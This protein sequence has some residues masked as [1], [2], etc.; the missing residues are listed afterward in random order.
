M[1]LESHGPQWLCHHYADPLSS[2]KK[3]RKGNSGQNP[4]FCDYPLGGFS[5]VS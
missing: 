1:I 2:L 5:S 4:G 3:E